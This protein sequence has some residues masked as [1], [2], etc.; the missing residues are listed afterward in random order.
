MISL[1]DIKKLRAKTRC[2]VMDCRQAL[3]TS[4]GD[5]KKAEAWL[6]K[7]GIAGADKRQ[8][9]ETKSGAIGVYLHH[10]KTMASLATVACETD[11]VARTKDFQ[12]LANEVAM[13]AGATAP[14]TLK[15]LLDQP[16]IR[17]TGKTI[18]DLVKEMSGKTGEKIE[19]KDFKR[20]SLQD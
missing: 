8:D 11:F 13:Q 19:V 9:R 4:G 18:N 16:W 20:L 7:K 14:K 17:D 5:M 12:S 2:G 1:Q 3:E 10:D 6:L 15:E